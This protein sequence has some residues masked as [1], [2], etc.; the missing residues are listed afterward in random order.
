MLI[1][2]FTRVYFKAVTTTDQNGHARSFYESLVLSKL[3]GS[4]HYWNSFF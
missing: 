3:T 2:N 1:E 4:F